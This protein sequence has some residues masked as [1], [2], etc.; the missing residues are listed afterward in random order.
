MNGDI[1][2]HY[3]RTTGIT[4]R[5][6]EYQNS[7]ISIYD[8]AG[9]R[10]ERKKWI[11]S[12]DIIGILVLAMDITCWNRPLYEDHSGDKM[13]KSYGLFEALFNSR[14]FK[15][16]AKILVF[17][18]ANALRAKLASDPLERF[19]EKYRGYDDPRLAQE[20][21]ENKFLSL[22]RM[23]DGQPVSVL[24]TDFSLGLTQPAEQLL[25]EVQRLRGLE[26]RPD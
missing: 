20:Y 9:A 12:F 17:T 7:R 1:M 25:N 13:R 16:L 21:L 6:F 5:S 22:Y 2:K 26:S 8:H 15:G 24:F 18:N 10:S 4:Q 19:E 3:I 23:E 11:H 14:W